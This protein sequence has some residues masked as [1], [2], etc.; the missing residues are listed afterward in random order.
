[1][2]SKTMTGFRKISLAYIQKHFISVDSESIK[3]LFHEDRS[4]PKTR[5]RFK[6]TSTF[7]IQFTFSVYYVH[8]H[9][10]DLLSELSEELY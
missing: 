3:L 6:T 9:P 10:D 1:M 4:L 7:I 5:E 2:R 8:Y